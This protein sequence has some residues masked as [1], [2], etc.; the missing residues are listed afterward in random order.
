MKH[1]TI[2]LVFDVIRRYI[3]QKE[4]EKTNCKKLV[5]PFND[6]VSDIASK[7][8]NKFRASYIH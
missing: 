5:H 1:E 2:K 6:N 3:E 8:L 7:T 4:M